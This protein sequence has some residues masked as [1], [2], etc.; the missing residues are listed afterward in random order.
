MKYNFNQKNLQNL[1]I[2]PLII[3]SLFHIKLLE[4]SENKQVTRGN[5]GGAAMNCSRCSLECIGAQKLEVVVPVTMTAQNQ[6]F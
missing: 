1:E 2:S 4:Y 5:S 3:K 6:T